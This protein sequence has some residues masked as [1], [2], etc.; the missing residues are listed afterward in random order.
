M[1]ILVTGGAGYVGSHT[2]AELVQKGEDVVVIDNLSTGHRNAVLNEWAIPFYQCDIHDTARVM[3]VM[4]DH[5]VDSVV[6][7]AASSLVAE[8]VHDPLKYY[9]NN[10]GGTRALL[11]A[12]VSCDVASIVLSSTAAVYGSPRRV[13]I[14]EDA[15]KEPLNP[16][17]ET[18]LAIER[19]LSYAQQA[20]GISSVSLRYFNAAGAHP[21][22]PIGEDHRPESHLIPIILQ[23]VL[24]QRDEILI[25]GDDYETRDGTCIRDYIHVCD[26]A[27]AHYLAVSHLREGNTG[28]YAFNLGNGSGFSVR[29]VI[30]CVRAISEHPVPALVAPRRA[31]DPAQLVGDA[32]LAQSVLGWKPTR[33]DLTQIVAD[34][35]RWHRTHPDG[36]Q[37]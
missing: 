8:S 6:H 37:G 4:T 9:A 22:L 23:V 15:N 27:S 1:S 2:V 29:E 32:S 17:G 12:M 3:K 26:L 13:P 20:Y 10:L 7:F 24:G 33:K 25:Y 5:H 18:K 34:A 14:S 35:W 30:D 28:S 16:Y 36:Y 21:T 11:D 19:M 31:G